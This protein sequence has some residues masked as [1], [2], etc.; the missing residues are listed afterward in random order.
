M[1]NLIT[2]GGGFVGSHL[3]DELLDRNEEV[4]VV[5]V[6]DGVPENL[7]H[8]KDNPNFQYI[9]GDVSDKG[10]L[11]EIITEEYDKIFHLAAIV[12][13]ENYCDRPLETIDVN[14]GGT[15][16]II[17][18]AVEKDIKIIFTSTSEVFGK[19]PEVPWSEGSDRVLG[20]TSI[21]RWSYSTSKSACEHMLYAV[22]NKYD[23]PVVI[24]RFFNAYG[25]RQKPIFAVPAM[26]KKV[27][28]NEDPIVYDSGEQTRCFTF[29][30]DAV[31]GTIKASNHPNAVGESFNI[32]NNTETNIKNLADKIIKVAGKEDKL[33]RNHIDTDE[34][35]DSYEDLDRR[36]PGVEKAKKILGW[37]ASMSLEEGLEKTLDYF[38]TK[39]GD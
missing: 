20:P 35:Y 29:V 39:V 28:N 23:L 22:H 15:R 7:V 4:T 12:G 30:K 3:T 26:I 37:E 2:G 16:N 34:L 32:G 36:V 1:K 24:V 17:D 10:K 13:V 11:E 38:R 21:D 31:E 6:E 19:N 14:I 9:K 18:I 8:N 5:D 25:P 33:E 27:L